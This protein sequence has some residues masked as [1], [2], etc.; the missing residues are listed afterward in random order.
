MHI[1]TC[2]VCDF[3]VNLFIFQY[4]ETFSGEAENNVVNCRDDI[5]QRRRVIPN[6]LSLND[7]LSSVG[8]N[9]N[10]SYVGNHSYNY[11]SGGIVNVSSFLESSQPQPSTLSAASGISVVQ[12]SSYLGWDRREPLLP[13]DPFFQVRYC[14][15]AK[16]MFV[17]NNI[18]LGGTR[19]FKKLRLNV[20]MDVKCMMS[21]I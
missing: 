14:I 11:Q 12:G 21:F 16:K 19:A 7:Q 10:L 1:E 5:D 2:C 4:E 9:T 6:N 18:C 15:I 20:N 3:N 8:V 17:M 13:I